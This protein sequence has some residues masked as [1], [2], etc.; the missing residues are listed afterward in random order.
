MDKGDKCL[1]VFLDLAKAFDS[2]PHDIL[3]CKLSSVGINYTSLPAAPRA[4]HVSGAPAVTVAKDAAD[5]VISVTPTHVASGSL[6]AT[7]ATDAAALVHEVC[8]SLSMFHANAHLKELPKF[9]GET[10]EWVAF[11]SIYHHSTKVGNISDNV[12]LLRLQRSLCGSARESVAALLFS[13]SNVTQIMRT[14]ENLFG[15]CDEVAFSAIKEVKGY[16]KLGEDLNYK[17]LLRYACKVRNLVATLVSLERKEWLANQELLSVLVSKLPRT[18]I[19]AWVTFSGKPVDRCELIHYFGDWLESILQDLKNSGATRLE[20]TAETKKLGMPGKWATKKD[21]RRPVM[22]VVQRECDLCGISHGLSQCDRFL[23][24]TLADRW[25]F[26]KAKFL[27][28]LCLTTG[29]NK[30]QCPNKKKLPRRRYH[31]LLTRPADREAG[32]GTDGIGTGGETESESSTHTPNVKKGV[33]AC[34]T[35]KGETLLKT[36]QVM[37]KGPSGEQVVYGLLDSGSA[38]TLLETA[39]ADALGLTGPQQT[40]YLSGVGNISV[41]EADSRAV[42]CKIKGRNM[43]RAFTLQAQTVKSLNLPILP[44]VPLDYIR[45]YPHLSELSC[46]QVKEAPKLL[47]GQDNWPL[48]ISRSIISRGGCNVSLSRTKLGFVPLGKIDVES[49]NEKVPAFHLREM[50]DDL[51]ELVRKNLE[52]ECLRGELEQ[53]ELTPSDERAVALLKK[54][55]QLEGDRWRT[56]LL[57]KADEICLPESE[58]MAS[59]RLRT[60]ETKMDRQENFGAVYCAKMEENIEKGY[61]TLVSRSEL[62]GRPR[63]W[64]LPHFAVTHPLKPG[65]LR[66]VFDGRAVSRGVS[67]NDCLLTGPDFYADLVGILWRFREG[68]VAIVADIK[69]MYLRVSI[70]KEDSYSQLFLWRGMDRENQPKIYRMQTLTF[71]ARSA[72]CSAQYVKN[73]NAERF[74]SEYPRAT[75]AIVNQCYMDDLLESTNDSTEAERLV[76]ETTEICAKGGFQ[77]TRWGSNKNEA[78]V[79]VSTSNKSDEKVHLNA[80]EATISKVLGLQWDP[81]KDHFCFKLDLIRLDRELVSGERWPTKREVLRLVMSIF[82]PIGY[83][84]PLLSK[85]KMILQ[86]IWESG[87]GWDDLVKEEIYRR[88]IA[89]LAQLR[90]VEE[91]RI[92]RFYSEG[93]NEV[94]STQ[95]HMFSD[96]SSEGMCAAG[97]L[98]QRDT[99]GK[100]RVNLIASRCRVSP[101]KKLTIP[102]LELNAALLAAKL[103]RKICEEHRIKFEQR[104]MW[105]DSSNVIHWATSKNQQ[106]NAYVAHRVNELLELT[107]ATE[108]RWVPGKLNPADHATR[109]MT[110][111]DIS[112]ESHWLR[113]PD[114]L[115]RGEGAWPRLSGTGGVINESDLEKKALQIR[116]TVTADLAL[117]KVERF[118]NYNRLVRAVAIALKFIAKCRGRHTTKEITAEDLDE[119]ELALLKNAQRRCYVA[120]VEAL[121]ER[122]AVSKGSHVLKLTPV[123]DERGLMCVGGRT[124]AAKNIPN[125]LVFPII[126]NDKDMMTGLLIERIHRDLNHAGVEQVL[127]A[128]RVKFWMVN[129]RQAVR[130]RLAKCQVCKNKMAKPQPPRMGDLPHERLDHHTR[131]FTNTAIDY[132]G[133]YNVTVGRRREIRYGVLFVCLT[134]R[135]VHLEVAENLTSDSAIQAIRRFIARRGTPQVMYSDNASTLR[136]AATELKRAMEKLDEEELSTALSSRRIRWKHVPPLSPHMAGAWERLVKSVKVSLDA[137]LR[138]RTPRAE[139]FYTLLLEVEAIVN[140]RPLTHV[141][142]DARDDNPLTP[143]QLLSGYAS[144]EPPPGKFEMKEVDLRKQWRIAQSLSDAFWRKWVSMYLPTLTNR[145]KWHEE[146]IP[147]KVGDVVLVC[148]GGLTRNN[149][150]KGIITRVFPD[151]EGRVRVAELQAGGKFYK[152]SA[153]RLA[154]LC[155]D[156]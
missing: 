90:L 137:V 89:W 11:K 56:G 48:I 41:S 80:D 72:A 152:R 147:L 70:D 126:L 8:Q 91:V 76:R 32:S 118:S 68:G 96:A 129:G 144:E 128:T 92:P 6:Q 77:L 151:K 124:A 98:R 84:A 111:I 148:D 123:L 156:A 87:S 2:V 141:S 125:S 93:L 139:T 3:L 109:S 38:V 102:R 100:V 81:V 146:A 50:G 60:L 14:L 140:L 121:R 55:T 142:L 71:G 1:G 57:W 51:H 52:L 62:E 36:V 99:F 138:N 54:T 88:W 119:A 5:A 10:M 108:W 45:A 133:P 79:S 110:A 15:D 74:R 67:L 69:D 127:S 154:R 143:Q 37:L 27:C 130:K 25:A 136:G 120:E 17:E 85:A 78:L 39:V 43:K 61:A 134:V 22:S 135:A 155:V 83:L 153:A 106:Y 75:Q 58:M 107:R 64:F 47:I 65:K 42:S 132:F 31:P 116:A 35:G 20:S 131:P 13:P 28:Y 53:S 21:A 44:S 145:K 115:S 95:L 82:D 73:V 33:V 59:K 26:A 29:H 112:P 150:P 117:A 16:V 40:L 18:L 9:S 30:F 105:A 4:I 34:A 113:G 104:F 122:G 86:S 63:V 149:W 94:V 101:L 12:N 114:Y 97:Y 49:L 66:V 19:A 7:H 23:T 46:C 103:A 24:K